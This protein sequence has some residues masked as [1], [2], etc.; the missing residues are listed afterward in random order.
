M[1]FGA[2]GKE[3]ARVHDLKDVEAILDA[4][5]QHGHTEIDTARVYSGGTCE[6]YLGKI[7]WEGRGL[8]METKLY[9]VPQKS[10]L[11]N[12]FINHTPESMRRHLDDSLK[13]LNTD[14]LEMWYLH[15]PDR[16]TPYEVTLKA[17]NEFYKEG[18]FKRFG[19]SNYMSYV[20]SSRFLAVAEGV[21]NAVIRPAGKWPKWF[22][23]AART[24]IS[25]RRSTKASIM[26]S[27]GK[28]L[29]RMI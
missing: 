9:P 23:S 3:G 13:A 22:R 7:D 5:Q 16:S 26:Q 1:T 21:G 6:E 27:T 24:G 14:T 25:S 18:K 12:D 29:R 17:V 11:F 28:Y 2:P 15:G 4:F 10:V 8:Q 19:I 20:F